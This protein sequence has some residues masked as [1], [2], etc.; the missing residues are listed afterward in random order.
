MNDKENLLYVDVL[1][2][3]PSGHIALQVVPNKKL[4]VAQDEH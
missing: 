4:P 2:K 1:P 3:Y